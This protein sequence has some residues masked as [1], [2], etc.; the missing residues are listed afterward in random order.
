MES[1]YEHLKDEVALGYEGENN[2]IDQL[3]DVAYEK[4]RPGS[5]YKFKELVKE[6]LFSPKKYI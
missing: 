3:N 1:H 5:P 6:E 2:K 4:L